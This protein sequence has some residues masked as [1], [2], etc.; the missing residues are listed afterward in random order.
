M[1]KELAEH[2][3]EQQLNEEVYTK[4]EMPYPLFKELSNQYESIIF[5]QH[6][7]PEHRELYK[8][9]ADWKHSTKALKETI[10]RRNKIELDIRSE[11]KI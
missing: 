8:N 3:S 1:S 2:Y 9:N 4:C 5:R 7:N 6:F 10:E 11:Y